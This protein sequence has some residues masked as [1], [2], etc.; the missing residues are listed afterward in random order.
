MTRC[1]CPPP[2]GNLNVDQ[3]SLKIGERFLLLGVAF[4]LSRGEFMGIIGPNG[5]GKSTLCRVLLGLWP[6]MAGKVYLDGVDLFLWDQE[7]VGRHI[8]YLPQEIELFPASVADNIARLGKINMEKVEKTAALCG[9]HEMVKALPNGYQTLLDS[10]D[11]IQL[12]GGQKQRLGLA[13]AIYGDPC[14]LVLDEPTSNLDEQGE[15]ELLKILSAIK[16]TK[17]CT[18]IMVTHKP[19]LLQSMD[20]ILVLQDGRVALFGPKDE[21]FAK[22]AEAQ[23]PKPPAAAA[24]LI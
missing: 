6:A 23:Q 16:E 13:R 19:G 17:A 14:L 18:C 20:K 24:R 10:R 8:G 3:V 1:S 15:Q 12:S 5:A 9:L 21:V 4:E 22:L 7:Q 2:K 11:G